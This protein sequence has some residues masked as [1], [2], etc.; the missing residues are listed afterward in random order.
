LFADADDLASL[1]GHY[2]IDSR[3]GFDVD[4]STLK[5]ESARTGGPTDFS[6]LKHEHK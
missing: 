1:I 2:D 3:R 5:A 4:E 6:L